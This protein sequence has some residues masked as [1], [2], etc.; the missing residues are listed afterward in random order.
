MTK[1]SLSRLRFS[2]SPPQSLPWGFCSDRKV[3]TA[4]GCD[5]KCHKSPAR[6][7][8]PGVSVTHRNILWDHMSSALYCS[9][10]VEEMSQWKRICLVKA[11]VVRKTSHA[12]ATKSCC[13]C[14]YATWRNLHQATFYKAVY[15]SSR[16]F[17]ARFAAHTK[18]AA[19]YRILCTF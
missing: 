6:R 2:F 9:T 10:W 1:S 4:L 3:I 14:T 18:T 11:A 15:S 16:Y 8:A 12:A 13:C 19:I 17:T 7:K 5:A